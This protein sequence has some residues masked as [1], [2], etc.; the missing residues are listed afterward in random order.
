MSGEFDE[1]WKLERIAGDGLVLCGRLDV[2]HLVVL[3]EELFAAQFTG[4]LR[5][6]LL[7]DVGQR[8][9]AGKLHKPE[10]TE[11]HAVVCFHQVDGQTDGEGLLCHENQYGQLQSD[12]LHFPCSL[13]RNVTS[14]NMKN[15]ALNILMQMGDD[16]ATNS[17]YLTYTILGVKGLIPKRPVSWSPAQS[18][19]SPGR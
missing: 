9:V 17:H 4:K 10:F 3:E 18:L 8:S 5:P 14:H 15:L 19:R 12:Q 6:Q 16:Y 13:T 7:S 2:S 1:D 11:P